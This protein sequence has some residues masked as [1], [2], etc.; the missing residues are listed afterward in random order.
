MIKRFFSIIIIFYI[1]FILNVS[2]KE[3]KIIAKVE[4]EIITSFQLKNKIRTSL[5]LANQEVNQIN[6]DKTKNQA[7]VS[8]INLKLK[9]NEI[10]KYNLV[11]DQ[12]NVNNQLAAISSNNIPALEQNFKQN[13]LDY[14]L[15][16]EEIEIQLAWQKLIFN[17]YGSKVKVN[18]EEIETDL[19]N[20]LK[21]NMNVEEFK[22]SEIEIPIENQVKKNEK[23]RFVSDQ[24]KDIGFENTAM[25]FSISSSSLKKGDLGWVNGKALSNQIY[26]IVRKLKIG[27]VSEPIVNLDSI[28]FLKL[29]DKKISKAKNIDT[30]SV[31]EN[32]IS[33]KKNELFNLY[34]KSHLSKIRNNALIEY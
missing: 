7:L 32:L 21:K 17:L 23:I 30:K 15:F 9:K 25:K 11:V 6:V 29:T 20:T 28:L 24:I 14:E 22:I 3:N 1:T 19:L 27:Q 4:N 8:L 31:K 16:I 13:N 10:T 34:S 18:D 26:E 5:I 12:V 2:S 33:Q